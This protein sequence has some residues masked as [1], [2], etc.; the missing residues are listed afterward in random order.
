[1]TEFCRQDW[2]GRDRALGCLMS[3]FKTPMKK[4]LT[5]EEA[6]QGGCARATIHP[7]KKRVLQQGELLRRSKSKDTHV[8]GI[9]LALNKPVEEVG[10][11]LLV[12]VDVTRVHLK[13]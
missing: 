6:S 11:V 5:R 4:K 10:V 8:C 12:D 9:T 2:G 3:L 7:N 13:V 1:V